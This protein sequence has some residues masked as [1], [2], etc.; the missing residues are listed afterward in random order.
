[1]R[2]FGKQPL[3]VGVKSTILFWKGLNWRFG[4]A[5]GEIEPDKQMARAATFLWPQAE[6]RHLER[7]FG[8]FYDATPCPIQ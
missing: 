3:G 2:A 4:N 6:K 1:M 7:E 5:K 8:G